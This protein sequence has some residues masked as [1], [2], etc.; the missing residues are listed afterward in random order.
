MTTSAAPAA[1]VVSLGLPLA[2]SPTAESGSLGPA[3]AVARGERARLA[4]GAEGADTAGAEEIE[5]AD[6]VR[7]PEVHRWHNRPRHQGDIVGPHGLACG[8]W[9]PGVEPL[10]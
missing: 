10:L 4:H 1:P 8:V 5:G 7:A 6:P 2:T 3:A 9:G